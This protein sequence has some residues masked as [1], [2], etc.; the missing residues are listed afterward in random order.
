MDDDYVRQQQR[1]EDLKR[2]ELRREHLKQDLAHNDAQTQALRNNIARLAAK[3]NIPAVFAALGLPYSPPAQSQPPQQ[4][5]DLA[6]MSDP[7]P[8][9]RTQALFQGLTWIL[10][11][12][13][14]PPDEKLAYVKA[15][16]SIVD[17]EDTLQNAR[18]GASGGSR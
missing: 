11:D 2:D 3:G 6:A 9:V 17:F 12:P 13:S 8:K 5:P 16:V 10:S 1:R 18:Q 15:M 4:V 14:L 7:N